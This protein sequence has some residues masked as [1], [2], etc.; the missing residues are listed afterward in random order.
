MEKLN[1]PLTNRE[2]ETLTLISKGFTNKEIAKEL[3]ISQHTAKAHISSI[4]SKLNAKNRT[5][6]LFIAI[7][8]N[9]L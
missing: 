4:I 7:Q 6:A 1:I 9:I 5:Q 8:W 3:I 2:K